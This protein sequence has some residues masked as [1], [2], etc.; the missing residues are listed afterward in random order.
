MIV[1]FLDCIFDKCI[2]FHFLLG[3]LEDDVDFFVIFAWG[4]VLSSDRLLILRQ[5]LPWTSQF[6]WGKAILLSSYPIFPLAWAFRMI[7][8]AGF[9]SWFV[10]EVFVLWKRTLIRDNNVVMRGIEVLLKA[11]F[12]FPE[13]MAGIID[14][15]LPH[16]CNIILNYIKAESDHSGAHAR[17]WS[18][19]IYPPYYSANWDLSMNKLIWLSYDKRFIFSSVLLDTNRLTIPQRAR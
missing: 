9:P 15:H 4:V 5:L 18:N 19:L 13:H 7:L 10:E 11:F 17:G 14:F 16:N 8:F 6:G 12:R 3:A 1:H 2:A